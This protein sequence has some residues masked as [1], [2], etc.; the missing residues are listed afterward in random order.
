MRIKISTKTGLLTVLLLLL[1]TISYF[2][3]ERSDQVKVI[4]TYPAT[5]CPA[6]GNDVSSIAGVTSPKIGRRLIDGTSRKIVPGRSTQIPLTKS[7]ILIEGNVGTALTFANS[8]W[9][10]VVPCSVSNGQQWFIGG[11]ASLTSKSLLYIVN[12]GFS[13]SNVSVE[14]FT[15][16]GAV[17][18]KNFVIPQNSTKRISVDTLAPGTDEIVIGVVTK[19]GRVSSFLFDERKKGLKSLGADFVSSTTEPS[20]RIQITAIPGLIDSLSGNNNSVEHTMRLFVPGK[21]D[22]NIEVT[23]ISNDGK[24]V[25]DGLSEVKLSAQKVLSIPLK[26]APSNQPFSLLINSEQPV[27]ASVLSNFTIGR[28][29][30][31]SWSTSANLLSNWSTNLTGSKPILSFTGNKIEVVIEA[32]GINGKKIEKNLKGQDFISWQSPVGLN[33]IQVF[34]KTKGVSGGLILLPLTGNIGLSSIPMNNGANL[35][36]A[37]EPLSD[38]SVITRR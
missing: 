6:I 8:K 15:P 33:R 26:T 9:K 11:S 32:N 27:L 21:I 19:S 24:F 17:E 22:A 38:A 7:S 5:V 20:K 14:V 1:A 13:D 34:A 30:E 31:I 28:S 35:E 36:T 25:P 23:I 16:N 10:A 37:S 18:E 2:A 29:N 12:S 3:P 4:S